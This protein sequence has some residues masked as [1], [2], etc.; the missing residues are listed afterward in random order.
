MNDVRYDVAL[1]KV[2][3]ANIAAF[4]QHLRE[5]GIDRREALTMTVALIQSL[6]A[7]PSES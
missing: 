2:Y 6:I 4:Y 7:R 3:A 5:F 1:M